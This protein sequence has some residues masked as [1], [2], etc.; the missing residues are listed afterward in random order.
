M[1]I[2]ACSSLK[3]DGVDLGSEQYDPAGELE[4]P[5]T[6]EALLN[7]VETLPFVLGFD[8]TGELALLHHEVV[9]AI[10]SGQPTARREAWSRYV[11]AAEPQV[12]FPDDGPRNTRAR[13]GLSIAKGLIYLEAGE[14]VEY[15]TELL[16]AEAAATA[17]GWADVKPIIDAEFA[18]YTG[19]ARYVQAQAN[20]EASRANYESSRQLYELAIVK[21]AEVEDAF[22]DD[23]ALLGTLNLRKAECYSEIVELVTSNLA[24]LS[25]GQPEELEGLLTTSLQA[26]AANLEPGP[27]LNKVL[28]MMGELGPQG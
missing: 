25:A 6:G 24:E 22:P 11:D 26:A 10:Q 20:F 13:A 9:A 28:A 14:S 7:P 18:K 4:T 2:E 16:G 23:L 17:C 12:D 19:T 8:E 27:E 5:E 1:S 3:G 21:Y 15:L